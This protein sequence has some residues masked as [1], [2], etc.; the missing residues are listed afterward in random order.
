[1]A[2]ILR[3]PTGPDSVQRLIIEGTEYQLRW[4]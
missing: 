1:M 2:V 3:G 4:R